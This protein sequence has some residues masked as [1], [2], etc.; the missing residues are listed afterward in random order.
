MHQRF[1]T[2]RAW[3]REL[4]TLMKQTVKPQ[5]N[6]FSG[7]ARQGKTSETARSFSHVFPA[8]PELEAFFSYL[9]HRGK[10]LGW[11]NIQQTTESGK[12]CEHKTTAVAL[13]LA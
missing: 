2:A 7:I 11:E 3:G 1:P 5:V 10:D 13:V 12:C 4:N 6:G 9:P 8:F